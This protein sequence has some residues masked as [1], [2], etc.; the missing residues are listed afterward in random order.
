MFVMNS[1][2]CEIRAEAKDTMLNEKDIFLVRRVLRL[3][4]G[5]SI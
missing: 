1:V 4:K 2:L 5:L 3:S